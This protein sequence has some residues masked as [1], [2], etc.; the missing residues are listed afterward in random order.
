MKTKQILYYTQTVIVNIRQ[1]Q[2]ND[3]L[4][5]HSQRLI[6]PCVRRFLFNMER[7]SRQRRPT[8]YKSIL[9]LL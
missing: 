2:Y 1:V 8:I 9:Y 4:I 5:V 6:A 7:S 3:I